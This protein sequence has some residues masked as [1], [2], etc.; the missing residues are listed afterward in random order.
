MFFIWPC[1]EIYFC[2]EIWSYHSLSIVESV[3]IVSMW[4]YVS[5]CVCVYVN[6]CFFMCVCLYVCVLCVYVCVRVH[7]CVC[8]VCVCVCVCV[9][10]YACINKYDPSLSVFTLNAT[11]K[12]IQKGKEKI[13]LQ[14]KK[15]C[16]FLPI[17]IV[18]TKKCDK[19]N[20]KVGDER[21]QDHKWK[22]GTTGKLL[23]NYGST[24]YWKL[25]KP[26]LT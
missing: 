13:V 2:S 18:Q 7:I 8:V 5:I 23:V 6:V 3:C 1:Y 10:L 12:W 22:L 25:N 17:P 24:Y 26:F 16:F 20:L 21:D 9:L 14:P 19:N 15:T 4:V 11:C